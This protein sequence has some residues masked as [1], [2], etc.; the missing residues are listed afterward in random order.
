MS[1]QLSDGPSILRPPGIFVPPAM[2]ELL[3][4]GVEDTWEQPIDERLFALLA[5]GRD[6]HATL[7]KEWRNA[8]IDTLTGCRNRRWMEGVGEWLV[9]NEPGTFS[10]AFVDLDGTKEKNDKEGHAA[11]NRYLITAGQTAQKTA[12]TINERRSG[13]VIYAERTIRVSGDEFMQIYRNLDNQEELDEK[14]AYLSLMLE[15]AGVRASIGGRPHRAGEP[16]IDLLSDIDKL[17]Y[18]QKLERKIEEFNAL[19]A[20]K[21]HLAQLGLKILLASGV[22]PP[23]SF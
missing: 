11:G 15:R 9:E 20:Y 19:P 8:R 5:V 10:A 23:R 2:P 16:W 14:M 4:P 7:V 13:S 22:K 12:D 21:R 18:R 17:M 1:E 3:L 6:R